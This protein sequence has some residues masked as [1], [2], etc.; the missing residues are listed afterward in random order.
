MQAIVITEALGDGSKLPPYMTP[1]NKTMSKRDYQLLIFCWHSYK[2]EGLGF[3][4][5][6]GCWCWMHS[7][8]TET[9]K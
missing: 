4:E 7:R 8:H 2:T 3:W 5:N 6:M 9:Q 1:N